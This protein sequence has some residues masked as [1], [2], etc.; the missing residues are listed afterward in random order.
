[1]TSTLLSYLKPPGLA[2]RPW[3]LGTGRPG[4][5]SRCWQPG[6]KPH[7]T[8]HAWARSAPAPRATATSAPPTSTGAVPAENSSSVAERGAAAEEESLELLEWPALCRQVACFTQTAIGAELALDC[9]LPLGR[10]QEES[11][12]LLQE[13]HEAQQA[14]LV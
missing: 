2:L 11:E 13:T 10:T 8:K 5:R 7:S 1:M 6:G 4:A 9:R 3:L 14:A 12:R